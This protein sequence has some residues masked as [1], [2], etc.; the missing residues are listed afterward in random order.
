MVAT[1]YAVCQLRAIP[2]SIGEMRDLELLHLGC[3][4][5]M[6]ALSL[7]QVSLKGLPRCEEAQ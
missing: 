3:P 7:M 1:H 5:L 4:N 6:L 2:P